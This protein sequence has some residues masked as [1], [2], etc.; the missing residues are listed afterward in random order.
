MQH[1]TYLIEFVWANRTCEVSGLSPS[2]MQ[3]FTDAIQARPIV[4]YSFPQSDTEVIIIKFDG[5][6]YMRI[7]GDTSDDK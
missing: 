5:L 4:F 6:Q 1:S 2:E 7:R 3:E